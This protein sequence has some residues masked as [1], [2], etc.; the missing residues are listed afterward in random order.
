MSFAGSMLPAENSQANK[1]HFHSGVIRVGFSRKWLLSSIEAG[2]SQS[3]RIGLLNI[4]FLSSIAPFMSDTYNYF[5]GYKLMSVSLSRLVLLTTVC[6]AA[7]MMLG[8]QLVLNKYLL[9]EE[10]FI[11]A[12]AVYT[13]ISS[14]K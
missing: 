12:Y 10:L 9:D 13:F 6:L 3:F 4:H 7:D 11:E 1:N 5:C 14:S 2:F 8:S